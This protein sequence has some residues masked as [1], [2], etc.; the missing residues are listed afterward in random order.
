MDD[1]ATCMVT[2]LSTKKCL[3]A[4]KTI[5]LDT[6]TTYSILSNFE[7][8]LV[9][10]L[11]TKWILQDTHDT[12][13][14]TGGYFMR[15]ILYFQCTSPAY[16][17]S[18]IIKFSIFFLSPT[19]WIP[20]L[21]RHCKVCI[22]VINFRISAYFRSRRNGCLLEGW[23]LIRGRTYWIIMCVGWAPVR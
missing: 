6:F 3:N 18:L 4:L 22:D 10:M 21:I 7:N 17:D 1:K 15:W 13:L 8:L 23:A 14:V 9:I 12:V 5:L 20:L 16:L 2:Y 19:I 11:G